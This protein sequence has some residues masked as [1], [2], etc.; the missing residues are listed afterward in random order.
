MRTCRQG[1]TFALAKILRDPAAGSVLVETLKSKQTDVRREAT[2]LLGRLGPK[3][4][5]AVA[6]LAELLRDENP[7]VR[8]A[9]AASLIKIDADAAL[10]VG[11]HRFQIKELLP[12]GA[13]VP[14]VAATVR[15]IRAEGAEG[16]QHTH[17]GSI[18]AHRE[19]S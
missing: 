5:E 11:V 19:W 15:W 14:D 3:A 8:K 7:Q 4:K 10:R 6:P 9:A 18:A 1:A 13:R 12:G 17:G 16:I 2:A